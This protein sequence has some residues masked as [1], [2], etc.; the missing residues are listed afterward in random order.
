MNLAL[1]LDGPID[2]AA[3]LEIFRRSV[4]DMIDRWDGEWLT[5]TIQLG[6][7]SGA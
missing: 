6:D 4:H 5:R 7:R 2:F 3:T 1:R